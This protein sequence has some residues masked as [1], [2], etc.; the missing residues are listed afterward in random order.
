MVAFEE[1]L[2]EAIAKREAA[3]REQLALSAGCMRKYAMKLVELIDN[4]DYAYVGTDRNEPLERQD[5]D[6]MLSAIY[7]EGKRRDRI[8][9]QMA[10]D[11]GRNKT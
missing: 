9:S 1:S 10:V 7:F 6:V 3:H 8:I 2:T 5:V 11:A 4:G